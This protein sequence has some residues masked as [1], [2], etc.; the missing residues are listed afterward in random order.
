MNPSA[1]LNYKFRQVRSDN[2]YAPFGWYSD[3][4]AGVG[5]TDYSFFSPLA[6]EGYDDNSS[7]RLGPYT[8][9]GQSSGLLYSVPFNVTESV[10]MSF[11]YK[12]A[13]CSGTS[14]Q[15]GVE[16]IFPPEFNTFD[17]YPDGGTSDTTNAIHLV[18]NNVS[19][20]EFDIVDITPVDNGWYNL[21]AS[22]SY[23]PENPDAYRIPNGEY[24]ILR[25]FFYTAYCWD[26]TTLVDNLVVNAA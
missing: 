9:Y 6:D 26:S 20:S 1:I 24:R 21:T 7:L 4:T 8:V 10:E 12:P 23:K 13:L 18:S 14:L 2:I 17:F 15:A 16:V 19:Y 11:M 22:K 5:F 3:W 25:V